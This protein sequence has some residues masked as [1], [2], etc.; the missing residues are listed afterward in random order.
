[1]RNVRAAYVLPNA[2]YGRTWTA[3][4]IA[5]IFLEGTNVNIIVG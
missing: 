2:A 5:D 4:V 3:S 1:M